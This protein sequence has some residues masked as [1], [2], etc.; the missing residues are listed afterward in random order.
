MNR[1]I[2]FNYVEERLAVLSYRI[3]VRSK[4]NILDLH[5]HS[6]DFYLH[7]LNRVFGWRLENVNAFAPNT[8]AIDLIDRDRKIIIQVSA[9]ATKQKVESAL[10]KDSLSSYEGY[11]FKFV[12][13]SK[14]A[15]H[16]RGDRFSNPH[17]LTFDPK[18]DVL[19]IPSILKAIKS[20]DISDQRGVHDFIREELGEQVSPERIETNLATVVTILAKEDLAIA[21]F[22]VKAFE[23]ERKIDF[24]KLSAAK[25][26]INDYVVHHAR[27]NRIYSEFAKQGANKSLSVLNAIRTVYLSNKPALSGDDLFFKVIDA[28]IEKV[29]SS[30]NYQSI[31]LEELELCVNILAVDAFIRCKIFENPEMY[32]YTVLTDSYAAS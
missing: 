21:G 26:I 9:T 19:D 18:S 4:L 12:S 29:Q 7:F 23:V 14:D 20:L 32:D 16:L 5:L 17:E 31:P 27:V 6:E 24:N 25:I 8:E 30:K 11:N 28:L 2:Y 13:I 10:A 3:E 22:Q 1:P 15:S